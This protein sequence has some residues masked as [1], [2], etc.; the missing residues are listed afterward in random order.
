MLC[1]KS[2]SQPVVLTAHLAG[3]SAS[4]EDIEKEIQKGI[5]SSV[6]RHRERRRF[7]QAVIRAHGKPGAEQSL[8]SCKWSKNRTQE[9]VIKKSYL[10]SAKIYS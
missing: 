5:Q 8:Q 4:L 10:V 6:E 9:P 3:R 2:Y 1:S 7:G